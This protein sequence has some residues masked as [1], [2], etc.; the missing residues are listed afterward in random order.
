MWIALFRSESGDRYLIGPFKDKE[1]EQ[2]DVLDVFKKQY[3]EE[4]EYSYEEVGL[5]FQIIELPTES[6]VITYCG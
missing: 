1:P 3:Q 2:E 5:R 6:K 4:A